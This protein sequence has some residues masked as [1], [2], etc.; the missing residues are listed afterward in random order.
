MCSV[1][2]LRVSHGPHDLSWEGMTE[3]EMGFL[4]HGLRPGKE[5]ALLK[6]TQSAVGDLAQWYL[7]LRR[8]SVVRLG[9]LLVDF[10]IC[11]LIYL[12]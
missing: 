6:S 10:R 3:E 1:W 2:R 4:Q 5:K 12:L 9:V 11:R 7:T 8:G